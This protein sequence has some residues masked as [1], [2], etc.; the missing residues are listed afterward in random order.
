MGKWRDRTRRELMEQ[1]LDNRGGGRARVC[2]AF[3]SAL[4]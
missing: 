4:A 1:V 3:F 2:L